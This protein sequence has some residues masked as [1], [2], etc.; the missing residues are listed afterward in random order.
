MIDRDY[1]VNFFEE[2]K[3]RPNITKNDVEI[4]EELKQLSLNEID[5]GVAPADVLKQILK[6]TFNEID[7]R[8]ILN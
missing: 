8:R 2:L 4:F 3:S 1:I 5:N 6:A 7:R